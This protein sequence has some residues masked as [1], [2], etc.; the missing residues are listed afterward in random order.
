MAASRDLSEAP[1]GPEAEVA[2]LPTRVRAFPDLTRKP[3]HPLP[4]S[5]AEPRF[6]LLRRYDHGGD[7]NAAC[8]S[9]ESSVPAIGPG[10]FM[11]AFCLGAERGLSRFG[12]LR[13]IRESLFGA[14]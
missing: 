2:T 10:C 5:R 8:L 11:A 14:L 6:L 9:I 1:T 7:V 12:Q 13:A 3:S 4:I